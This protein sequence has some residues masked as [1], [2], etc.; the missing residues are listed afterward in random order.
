MI[1]RVTPRHFTPE[2]ANALLPEVRPAAERLVALADELDRAEARRAELLAHIAGNGGDLP[3]SELAE[4]TEA[5]SSAEGELGRCV[6]RLH[7]LGVQVKDVRTGL[8]DFPARHAGEEVL[9]CW[10]VGE[11]SVD[12][13]HGVEEGFAGRK[14]LPFE[15]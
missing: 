12:H 15:A 7:A 6:R 5:V 10:R 13:W 2:E 14:P 11:D 1:A 8:V 3:P 9:L 4:A